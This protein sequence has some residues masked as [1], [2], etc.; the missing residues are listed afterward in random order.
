MTT[1][2]IEEI[3]EFLDVAEATELKL[4]SFQ[5]AAKKIRK[6]IEGHGGDVRILYTIYNI[7]GKELDK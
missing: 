4:R 6:R 2:S 1:I 5:D 7:L 3:T